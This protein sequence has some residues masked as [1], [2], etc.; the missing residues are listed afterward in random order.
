VSS[1]APIMRRSFFLLSIIATLAT[2]LV[3]MLLWSAVKT[4]SILTVQQTLDDWRP[5]ITILRWTLLMILV[6][7]WPLISRTNIPAEHPAEQLRTSRLKHW[8]STRWRIMAWL[9]VLELMLGQNGFALLI[10]FLK[11]SVA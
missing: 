2:L 1:K 7:C 9:F 8:L 5:P 6:Q 11:E 3:G 4:Q 10:L